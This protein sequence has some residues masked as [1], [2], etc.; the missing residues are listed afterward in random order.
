M[1]QIEIKIREKK[2]NRD[3]DCYLCRKKGIA[4]EVLRNYNRKTAEGIKESWRWTWHAT[5][6]KM[7]SRDVWLCK[8]CDKNK[9]CSNCTILLTNP[10]SKNKDLNSFGSY[11]PSHPKM[12]KTCWDRKQIKI[13]EYKTKISKS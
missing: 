13:N 3:I 11:Y 12:C 8:N 9:R 7:L 1:K 5:G 6:Y 10:V 4:K 2:P